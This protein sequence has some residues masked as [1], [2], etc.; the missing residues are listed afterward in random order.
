MTAAPSPAAATAADSEANWQRTPLFDAHVRLGGQMV[1][2][3]GWHMPVQYQGHGLVAEHLAT[4]SGVGLFDVS[5][6]GEIIVEGPNAQ[7]EVNRLVSNDVSKLGEG[8]A[9]Y[10][11]L[12]HPDGGAVDDLYVYRVGAERFFLVVNAANTAKDFEHIQQHAREPQRIHNRSADFAQIA[13]QGPNAAILLAAV[14]PGEAIGL[15]RN[16]IRVHSFDGADMLVAT[17]GYTG[18]SG[19]EIYCAPTSAQALWFALLDAGRDWGVC[20]IGLGARDTLRLE[21][22]YPLYGH[23]LDDHTNGYEAR[24]GWAMRPKKAGGFIGS[25]PLLAVLAAGPTKKLVGLELLDRGVPRA[26]YAV[27]HA[28]KVVGKVTSGTHSPCLKK[29]IALAYVPS[30]LAAVGTELSIDV[31]GQPKKA[32][33]VAFPFVQPLPSNSSAA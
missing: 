5:H 23:E 8:D 26:D 19:F 28:G 10:A 13:V 6:M 7:A 30:E 20:P 14:A 22:G 29:P 11:V 3:A 15:P 16:R 4:R 12:C 9:C 33:V 31:R 24:V 32:V 2:Y 21:M 27:L 1:E 18:E 17:T 25:E